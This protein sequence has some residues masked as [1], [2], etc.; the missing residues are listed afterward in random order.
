[1]KLLKAD[2]NRRL[3]IPG[4]PNLVRRPVD[5]DKSQTGFA[6]L[7]SLRIYRFDADSEINGHAEED[8]V[9]IVV[10]AGTV[11]LAM[12]EH[13]SVGDARP[14]TLSEPGVSGKSP[15]AAYL[16]PHAAYR[17]IPKGD[18]DIAYARATPAF[19]RPPSAFNPN[20]RTGADGTSVLLEET[21][22]AQRLRLRLVKIDAFQGKISI[23]PIEKSEE[24]FEALVHA[25]TV[26]AVSAATIAESS[27]TPIAL[28]S[29]DTVA[30]SPG[31]HCRVNF[32][33]G[34][35]ALVLVVLAT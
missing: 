11:D 2:H 19:G 31:E 6:N 27:A 9:L 20:V 8:E 24:M 13:D 29:W 12:S 30:V 23:A 17:L 35:S 32:A 33:K 21:S 16:P 4:V 34:S 22:Y 14:V 3:D 5:I 15:C 1:M 7:R 25:K 18:A 26:P 10:M 28:E